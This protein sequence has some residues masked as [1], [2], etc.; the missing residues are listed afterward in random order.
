M[1]KFEMIKTLIAKLHKGDAEALS[2]AVLNHHHHKRNFASLRYLKVKD[3][4]VEF[5]VFI[6]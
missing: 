5:H 6:L 1:I 3:F 4:F 2:E